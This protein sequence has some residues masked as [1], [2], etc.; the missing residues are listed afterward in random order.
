MEK[1]QKKCKL[2]NI[3]DH[4]SIKNYGGQNQ[5]KYETTVET[6]CKAFDVAILYLSTYITRKLKDLKRPALITT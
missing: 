6:T 3:L 5:G 4:K 2:S 1:K